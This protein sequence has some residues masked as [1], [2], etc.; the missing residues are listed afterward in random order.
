MLHTRLTLLFIT[1]LL[2]SFATADESLKTVKL[3]AEDNWA[4]FAKASG[5]GVSHSLINQAF[6]TVGVEVDSIVVP[7]SR[8][9]VMAKEGLVDGVFN[10]VKEQSTESE[11][12]FG[13]Q[14]LFS[15]TASFYHKVSTPVKAKD[16]W[17]LPPNTKVGII[18]GYEYGDE[19]KQLP[20]IRLITLSN[21]NQLINLLLLD[22]IDV[23]IMY[24]LVAKQ[25][26]SQMGVSQEIEQI[27]TNHTGQVYLAFSKLN[28]HASKLAELLDRGLT[29]L[30][31]DGSYQ[32][33]MASAGSPARN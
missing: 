1:S 14:P 15:A 30:K 13:K 8:A 10:L 26:I 5:T 9:V 22:R 17:Q 20:N 29:T 12:I 28:P 7:Y 11:F 18:R 24:D 33:I 19:L 32:E 21:H 4:P 3:A 6:S 25:Y 2:C 16:K 27:F 23:A 31:D